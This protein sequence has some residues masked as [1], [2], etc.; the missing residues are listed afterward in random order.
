MGIYRNPSLNS[1]FILSPLLLILYLCIGFIPN[2]EAVDKIAPQWLGMTILNGISLVYISFNYSFFSKSINTLIK[3]VLFL[4]YFSFIF[5]SAISYFYAINPTEVIVNITRQAN[6]FFMFSFMSVL[7]FKQKRINEFISIVLILI[8]SIEVY[9]VLDQLLELIRVDGNISNR[10]NL[11]GV[12]AN[13]NITAFSIVNKIPFLIY[14]LIKTKKILYKFLLSLLY[15]SALICISVIQSRASFVALGIILIS[16]FFLPFIYFEKNKKREFFKSIFFLVFPFVISVLINQIFIADKGADAI[17]RASTISIT[18]ADNSISARLRYYSH[19]LDQIK[20]S[21][22]IGVGLGNWKIKSIEYESKN[23]NGYVVPYHAHSDFIQLGA[24]LGIIGFLLYLGIFIY[25]LIFGFM[26]ILK[27]K[28]TPENKFF[29]SVILISILTYSVDANLNF[30]IA[31]PQVLTSWAICISI[32]LI[33]YIKFYKKKVN[34][35]LNPKLGYLFLGLVFFVLIP[36]LYVTNTVFRSLKGQMLLLQDFNSNQYNVPLNQVYSIVPDIPNITVT[37]I[38][39]NSVKARYFVNA[40]KYDKALEL[41]NKGTKANPYLYYSEILKSQI[42]QE[43][44]KLDSAKIYAKKAFM[45]L[46]NND[47]HSTRYINLINITQDKKSLDES[48]ELLTYKNKEVNWKN[49]LII[50]SNLYA[51][52]DKRFLKRAK[53]AVEIFPNNPVIYGLYSKALVGQANIN[54]A[55]VF[56]KKGLE[57]FEKQNYAKAAIEFEK[58]IEKNPFNYAYYENA[59]SALYMTGDLERASFF[60]DKVIN[61]L[62][63]L[64]G[65]CEYIKALI[66]LKY[67]DPIGAC[68]FIETAFNSG[69]IQAKNLLN[70]YCRN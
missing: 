44:G 8:L 3:S 59:A 42:F 53:K 62:N 14:I 9:Y 19:V 55:E 50:G 7:L 5:W 65:K 48:Y 68:P 4:I 26:M 38:P 40:K 18:N 25:V 63:P 17:Q 32:I 28:L 46:P 39:I 30:P 49:Y 61:E 56:S 35:T 66:L 34:Q 54:S 21:P 60:I 27:S 57:Y 11:K 10:A 23:I 2:L 12:A 36:S 22:F 29:I 37:T 70:Q 43:L 51:S 67:Q 20:S 69:Y 45:G 24:E 58:S 13:P 6:V 31:R 41:L 16:S 33:F 52:G 64:N 47:L 1:S 15:I